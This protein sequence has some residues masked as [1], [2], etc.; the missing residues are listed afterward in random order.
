MVGQ[1]IAHYRL[2]K[3]VGSGGMGAVYE[4]TDERFGTRVA[5]KLLR[6]DFNDN[7]EAITRFI[8]EA[9]A[10][11]LVA[12]P[13]LVKVLD[14][15]Q[16][17]DG[18]A[19]LVMEFL[20]GD[21]LSQRLRRYRGAMPES[22]VRRIGWQLASGL[23]AAH[24]KSI[25]HR[26][27]KPG[28]IMLVSDE[29]DAAQGSPHERAKILD[30][31]IAKLDVRSLN[32]DDPQTRAGTLMGTPYYMS[33][34]QCRGAAKVDDRSDVY[35]LGVIFFQMLTGRLPFMPGEDGDGEGAVLA[36]HVYEAPPKPR[37]LNPV[38][39]DA[40]QTLVL[41]M[42]KKDRAT[43][44]SMAE[45]CSR[46]EEMSGSQS[47]ASD[48][49]ITFEEAPPTGRVPE[50][51]TVV[52]GPALS[53]IPSTLGSGTGQISK[54][55]RSDVQPGL[56][57]PF[58]LSIELDRRKLAIVAG[59]AAGLLGVL[60]LIVWTT[61]SSD[62]PIAKQAT[63]TTP[64]PGEVAATHC[65]LLSEPLGAEVIREADGTKLGKTPWSYEQPR[66]EGGLVLLLKY[67]G[68]TDRAM[69][70]DCR[71][72]P[73]HREQLERL[74]ATLKAPPPSSEDDGEDETK[75]GPAST[76]KSSSKTSSKTSSKSK[77]K[78]ASGSKSKSKRSTSQ[79]PTKK[80]KAKVKQVTVLE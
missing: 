15:G 62:Q 54:L 37:D 72:G 56:R 48:L 6:S 58:D 43:R 49:S 24:K 35:S 75:S 26:D 5:V 44:P 45:V 67:P 29:A 9:A 32:L 7:R 16:L 39:S 1:V 27:L 50:P 47:M 31:G 57:L 38:V 12:H 36:K 40:M 25:V 63:Q 46:L 17:A 33:P 70:L 19:Y 61:R 41:D 21:T 74:P 8:N 34:E 28:N 51:A 11:N 60:L 42:L 77:A 65:E 71:K 68:Y 69:A 22:D 3:Q 4:A 76:S 20:E 14:S 53:S 79:K 2:L 66:G 52:S 59:A 30:F 55:D 64:V 78:A 18:T 80:G 23:A 10:A 13:S 73:R